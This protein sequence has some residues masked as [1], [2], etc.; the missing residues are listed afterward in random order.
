MDLRS[1]TEKKKEQATVEILKTQDTELKSNGEFLTFKTSSKE[2]LKKLSPLLF[3][4]P[5]E[6]QEINSL[7]ELDS[8]FQKSKEAGVEGLMLKSLDAP[9]KPGLRTGAM[10]KLKE[11]MEDLD[12]VILGAEYGK[13]KRSG[14]YS[15]F[16][17]GLLDDSNEEEVKHLFVGKVSSGV[18]ELGDEG[19]SLTKLQEL[20]EPLK[21]GE[22]KGVVYFEAQVIVQVKYQEIQPSTSYDSG[23]ALRFPRLIALRDDKNLEEI[24]T[25]SEL[26]SYFKTQSQ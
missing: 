19:I 5:T 17:V 18:K 1:F 14:F 4:A 23:F 25:L 12:L 24:S 9:Y 22:E 11:T 8:F 16:Y 21:T 20:L 6:V 10:A 2:D 15:S 7:E 26:R 3:F 13:G